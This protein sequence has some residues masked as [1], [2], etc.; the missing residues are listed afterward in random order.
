MTEH[1]TPTPDGTPSGVAVVWDLGN[2]LIDWQPQDAVAAG[3]GPEEAARF[4]AAEDFDF[5]AWN[6][7]QDAGGGWDDAEAEVARTHPH[8]AEHAR[9]Y[10]THFARSLVGEVPGTVDLLRDLH[11][12]GVVQWGLTNWSAELYPHA[13]ERF[14]FLALLDGVVVSGVEGV[15]KPDARAFEL[16]AERS[17][18]PLDQMVFVDDRPANVAA[19][20]ALGMDGIVFTGAGPLRADLRRRGLPV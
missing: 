17:G 4:L 3:V 9:A 18:V 7:V 13:P 6:H 16:V 2:V 10:R 19:A 1:T 14:D 5:L 8:W 11:R 12:A 15:A 20:V